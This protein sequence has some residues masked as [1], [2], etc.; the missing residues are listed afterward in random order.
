MNYSAEINKKML[1]INDIDKADIRLLYMPQIPVNFNETGEAVFTLCNEGKSV[2]EIVDTLIECCDLSND[3]RE[4]VKNDVINNL[5]N[6][7]KVGV[8]K[9]KDGVF[10]GMENYTETIDGG[11]YREY[12]IEDASFL[13]EINDTFLL[14]SLVVTK[15][16]KCLSAELNM[17]TLNVRYF[18]YS[19]EEN[20]IVI[21][22]CYDG[23]NHQINLRGVSFCG[24]EY[25]KELLD[26][27]ISWS[28]QRYIVKSAYVK[29]RMKTL[30]VYIHV[31]NPDLEKLLQS[32]EFED[33]GTLYGEA[34]MADVEFYLR[35]YPV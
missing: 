27:L 25:K 1:V 20:R 24:K 18:E 14:D 3:Q 21:Q 32:Q 2:D 16:D 11:V 7:W 8:I 29:N 23:K 31:N 5:A 6:L 9:W 19:D 33:K 17:L 10:P 35:Y 4:Q 26:K 12:T 28:I 34:N 13:E 30:P 15:E 22:S